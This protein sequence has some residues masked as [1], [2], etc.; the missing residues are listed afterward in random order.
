MK[1]FGNFDIMAAISESAKIE[2]GLHNKMVEENR[3]YLKRL[4]NA[5]LRSVKPHGSKVLD[6][7][8]DES[9]RMSKYDI[10]EYKL[11]TDLPTVSW[12]KS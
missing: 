10:P 8:Q 2:K 4:V 11:L 5:I 6:S 1:T 3:D 12:V 9:K 7:R